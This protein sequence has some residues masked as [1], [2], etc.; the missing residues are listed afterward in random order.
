MYSLDDTIAAIATPLGS[1]GV[2]IIKISGPQAEPIARQIFRPARPADHFTPRTLHYGQIIYPGANDPIDEALVAFMPGPHSYTRQDVVEIQSHG[3]TVA[4]QE[5][6]RVVLSLGARPATPGEMTLRAFINGRLDL[7][8]AESVM[9]LIE[10]K[11]AAGLRLAARQL[12]GALS[13]RI[14]AV[15]Q[16]LV[17]VL[18]FL[19]A[20]IDFVEDDIPA[21]NIVPPLTEAATAIEKLAQSATYGQIYRQGIR[22]AIVGKPNVGKSSLLNALLRGDRAIVTS[23]PGTTRDTLEETANI[24][25]V[26]LVLVD[27]AGIRSQAGDAVEQIG[28]ERSRAALAQADLALMVVDNSAPP[29]GIDWEIEA[30]VRGKPALL[31]QNKIDLP[32]SHSVPDDFLPGIPRVPMSA[33][34]GQGLEALET[35]IVKQ[36]TGGLVATT[37]AMLVSNPR[38]QALLEQ[39]AGHTR[40]AIEAQLANLSPDLVSIDVREAVD[41]LGE[42]TGQTASEDLLDA[43]FSKFCIGK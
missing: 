21:E 34:T 5:I 33:L 28:I 17:N 20:S 41:A 18:A 2:G 30:L 42:I 23:I 27:T 8:Q 14:S 40:A 38:H 35:M 3:G 7:A 4:L 9:D 32:G 24:G 36:I 13:G 29:E 10:A 11:T 25:G 31:V 19:E 22:T 1:G 26:P 6:L 12:S 37:D 43:I 16:N 39:A 15:R